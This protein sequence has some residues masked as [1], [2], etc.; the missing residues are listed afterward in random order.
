MSVRAVG[1]FG[2]AILPSRE[3][4]TRANKSICRGTPE[5]AGSKR[6]AADTGVGE[7]ATQKAKLKAADKGVDVGESAAVETQKVVHK[8]ADDDQSA[9]GVKQK[10][11]GAVGLCAPNRVVQQTPSEDTF[12]SSCLEGF[13]EAAEVAVDTGDEF[14]STVMSVRGV[15]PFGWAVLPSREAKT[16]ANKSICRHISEKAGAKRKA[17]DTGVGEKATQ[18]AKLKA[19]DNDVDGGESAAVEMQKAVEKDG[20]DDQSA[21]GVKQMAI[22]AVGLCAPNRVVQQTPSED[23][24]QSSCLEGFQEAAEVAVSAGD[25]F[26]STVMSVRGVGPF[27]WAV[28]PSREA[29]TRANK[30][31]CGAGVSESACPDGVKVLY[32][33]EPRL[34]IYD[35]T[36]PASPFCVSTLRKKGAVQTR[37]SHA[38]LHKATDLGRLVHTNRDFDYDAEYA[39]FQYHSHSGF[40][41]EIYGAHLTRAIR[42]EAACKLKPEARVN[43]TKTAELLNASHIG[44]FASLREPGDL[45]R[46]QFE[47]RKPAEK[48]SLVKL[49]DLKDHKNKIDIVVAVDRPPPGSCQAYVGRNG[50]AAHHYWMSEKGG[51]ALDAKRGIDTVTIPSNVDCKY[52]SKKHADMPIV[53]NTPDV[54]M[55]DGAPFLQKVQELSDR[56][57]EL[58]PQFVT[59]KGIK[60]DIERGNYPVHWGINQMDGAKWRDTNLGRMPGCKS[61]TSKMSSDCQALA[62]DAMALGSSAV[63]KSLSAEHKG[64]VVYNVSP[65]MRTELNH[66]AKELGVTDKAKADT[67]D[68]AAGSAVLNCHMMPCTYPNCKGHNCLGPQGDWKSWEPNDGYISHLPV[69]VSVNPTLC[70]TDG[71]NCKQPGTN[72]FTVFNSTKKV[73]QL[74]VTT[75]NFLCSHGVHPSTNI[76]KS[77]ILYNRWILTSCLGAISLKIKSDIP[78]V[79]AIMELKSDPEEEFD[80]LAFLT[81]WEGR[82]KPYIELNLK[83]GDDPSN[84]GTQNITVNGETATRRVPQTWP[85]LHVARPVCE[86]RMMYMSSFASDILTLAVGGLNDIMDYRRLTQMAI[87]VSAGHNNGQMMSH[88]IFENWMSDKSSHGKLSDLLS[89]HPTLNLHSLYTSDARDH[90][91]NTNVQRERDAG[92]TSNRYQL[93]G[94]YLREH[95]VQVWDSSQDD[96]LPTTVK[97]KMKNITGGK[98]FVYKYWEHYIVCLLMEERDRGVPKDKDDMYQ[99]GEDLASKV[100]KLKGYTHLSALNL[101]Q[102]AGMTGLVDEH[103]ADWASWR[104]AGTRKFLDRFFEDTLEEDPSWEGMD[105]DKLGHTDLWYERAFKMHTNGLGVC[106]REGDSTGCEGLRRLVSKEENKQV[107]EKDIVFVSKSGEVQNYFRTK[108][109][110]TRVEMRLLTEKGWKPVHD[111]VHYFSRMSK[112]GLNTKIR[113]AWHSSNKPPKWVMEKCYVNGQWRFPTSGRKVSVPSSLK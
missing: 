58:L 106:H 1:S 11:V 99:R 110:K 5:K 78:S 90:P 104:G 46:M 67:I 111:I 8:D 108:E 22:G 6:K 77:I 63:Q 55:V 93:G 49:Y 75:H 92:M 16:R 48:R 71:S 65:E 20:D 30:S 28:S 70:H 109:T 76:N 12:Q 94:D 102:I 107:R 66:V 96:W 9:A 83:R 105:K 38:E 50:H 60:A 57:W 18:R 74:P 33:G 86:D 89:D 10:A 98:D 14:H 32:D 56:Y 2:W 61:T 95:G 62:A 80:Y 97:I 13:Q 64:L 43:K 72:C 19:A 91:N 47:L 42:K 79:K 87:C 21:A 27:G 81:D 24:F 31:I 37:L 101:I 52:D 29:K 35:E 103:F 100:S 23:T 45:G 26:H 41:K 17:A 15:G 25:E 112:C 3:A 39:L 40:M 59:T 88:F 69:Q 51:M 44:R 53:I 82:L 73:Q 54:Y 68:C 34:L 7:K 113:V 84:Y 4:K 36:E 85:W